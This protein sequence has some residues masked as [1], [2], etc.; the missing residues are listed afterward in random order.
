MFFILLTIGI[1]TLVVG[2][3]LF[4]TNMTAGIITTIVGIIFLVCLV[5]YYLRRGKKKGKS[6]MDGLNCADCSPI[7]N[8]D[9][10]LPGK[11]HLD[12]SPDCDC[13]CSPN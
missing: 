5:I 9:F 11:R 1:T 12:C 8:C 6:S 13:D 3:V 7:G 2:L 10:N 4:S